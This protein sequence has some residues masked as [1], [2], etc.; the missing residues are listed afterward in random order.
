M[1]RRILHTLFT[2]SLAALASVGIAIV[3]S[4]LLGAE[5][6]GDQSLIITTVSMILVGSNLLAGAALVYLAPRYRLQRLA[7][8]AVAWSALVAFL[9]YFLLRLLPLVNAQFILDVALLSFIAA[10]SGMSGNFLIGRERIARANILALL[11]PVLVLAWLGIAYGFKGFIELNDYVSALYFSFGIN[12][13]LGFLLLFPEWRKAPAQLITDGRPL[14]RLMWHYGMMNQLSHILQL[15]SFRM[16]FYFLDAW[17]DTASVGLYSNA[18]ALMESVW[19]ISKSIAVVQYAR[20]SNSEDEHYKQELTL[21]LN[22]AVLVITLAVVL[23][24]SVLPSSL[25]VW[26]FGPEFDGL[27]SLMR[28]L[29]P[30]TLFYTMALLFGHYFSGNGRYHLNTLASFAGLVVALLL[31]LLLIPSIGAAGA[32]LA[33]SLSYVTTAYWAFRFFRKDAG[34]VWGDLL[35]KRSDWVQIKGLLSHKA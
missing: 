5:G 26:I 21:S 18:V 12:T 23:V 28:L 29:A 31:S 20:I 22:R 14:L 17:V 10:L 35:F 8:P 15:L 7:F 11:Q 2:R 32:A 30:G 33:S 3:V 16:S 19:L 4:R 24:L 6:K 1:F 13:L 34:A 9:S 27:P 25:W